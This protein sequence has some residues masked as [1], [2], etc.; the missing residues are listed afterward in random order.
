VAER[1]KLFVDSNVVLYLLS[2]DTSKAEQA[3][4]LLRQRPAISVQV[5]NE[6]THVCRRKLGMAWSEIGPFL[7][8]IKRLCHVVPL[9]VDVHDDARRLAERYGLSFYDACIVAAARIEGCHA[10]YTEDMHHGLIVE[11]SLTLRHPFAPA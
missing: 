2:A 5:L 1:A 3:E 4:A 11:D 8:V 6:V 10:L 9:T 7:D